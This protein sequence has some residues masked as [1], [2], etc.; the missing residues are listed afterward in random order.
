M[1]SLT[2]STTASR[3][4]ATSA[5]KLNSE[6]VAT[7]KAASGTN[8]LSRNNHIAGSNMSSPT[9]DR[10]VADN[11]QVNVPIEF[12]QSPSSSSQTK[13]VS[14]LAAK[15][16]PPIS[17]KSTSDLPVVANQI[18]TSAKQ[19]P[20]PSNSNA[21]PKHVKGSTNDLHQQKSVTGVAEPLK[22]GDEGSMG[23]G[24]LKLASA[25]D[26]LLKK[27]KKAMRYVKETYRE[28][29]SSMRSQASS[30][31]STS[32]KEPDFGE[33][34][35]IPEVPAI[36]D[37]AG[38]IEAALS[39]P[40]N[41]ADVEKSDLVVECLNTAGSNVSLIPTSSTEFRSMPQKDIPKQVVD[42]KDAVTGSSNRLKQ[43]KKS[44]EANT[45]DESEEE[46]HFSLPRQK[47]IRDMFRTTNKNSKIVLSQEPIV[48]ELTYAQLELL[49]T[50]DFSHLDE[51]ET[52]ILTN[53]INKTSRRLSLY[54]SNKIEVINW[55]TLS[56]M[57][58]NFFRFHVVI[59]QPML[60]S[61][62]SKPLVELI[63]DNR[64]TR[65]ESIGAI[66]K[67]FST[68]PRT[69][70]LKVKMKLSHLKRICTCLD[71]FPDSL[72]SPISTLFA[73]WVI[74]YAVSQRGNSIQVKDLFP[75]NSYPNSASSPQTPTLGFREV[76][77]LSFIKLPEGDI[78]PE[79]SP[80][81]PP[82]ITD[83]EKLAE[84]EAERE[85]EQWVL[86]KLVRR[87]A[88]DN[89]AAKIH[90]EK[91]QLQKNESRKN[92]AKLHWLDLRE[93]LLQMGPQKLG[94][95]IND[96]YFKSLLESGKRFYVSDYMT[97][98]GISPFLFLEHRCMTVMA[99]TLEFVLRN[100]DDIF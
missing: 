53:H 55:N 61:K 76:K 16:L 31:L 63:K 66:K 83:P 40:K 47:S 52:M 33:D 82:K 87:M 99:A 23:S 3:Q 46:D 49:F 100:L 24:I 25:G 86:N 69:E 62:I 22:G 93:K 14:K 8:I 42:R 51:R 57:I 27:V 81:A 74:S 34:S 39:V 12:V 15:K 79:N 41:A 80:F 84:L 37:F 9:L 73:P 19:E 78:I 5:T 96:N 72:F 29:I 65:D 21:V 1:L 98:K 35:I 48:E 68:V 97:R 92:K 11:N 20:S 75:V 4:K 58:T 64:L 7:Q 77:P 71:G 36:P 18:T 70:L 90:A 67:I 6:V 59:G 54:A 88:K 60:D 38:K 30:Y 95:T 91:E 56:V 89:A 50:K 2:A 45:N 10:K 17:A 44:P 43:E 28:S 32:Q 13:I 26:G 85:F 94:Q